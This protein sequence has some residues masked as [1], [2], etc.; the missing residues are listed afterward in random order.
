M[1]AFDKD[2][3]SLQVCIGIAL[4]QTA[5]EIFVADMG[6]LEP[7]WLP[8]PRPPPSPCR[9]SRPPPL[10]QLPLPPPQQRL[11]RQLCQLQLPSTV[12]VGAFDPRLMFVVERQRLQLQ[13]PYLQQRRPVGG[14][15]IADGSSSSSSSPGG[16]YHRSLSSSSNSS[17]PPGDRRC[18]GGRSTLQQI[19]EC[20]QKCV[21]FFKI[22]HVLITSKKPVLF[23]YHMR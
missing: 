10:L 19:L 6:T 12:D 18:N 16:R 3:L 2:Q 21:V 20:R 9:R 17:C 11:G 15:F 13:Q 1:R 7:F 4:K 23:M 22:Y 5:P 8:L 14:G